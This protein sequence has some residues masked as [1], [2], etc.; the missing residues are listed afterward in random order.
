LY[1]INKNMKFSSTS[2][3][4]LASTFAFMVPTCRSADPV[5]S[6]SDEAI[7]TPPVPP[8]EPQLSQSM[9]EFRHPFFSAGFDDMFDP[10]LFRHGLMTFLANLQRGDDT[11]LMRSSPGYE[12]HED[13]EKYSIAIDVP[14]VKA[15]D[16]TITLEENGHVLNLSGGR[17]IKKGDSVTETKFVKTFTI[18]DN[19]DAD[20][21]AANLSDG[22]LEVTA[23]K[24]T[25]EEK[26]ETTRV[27]Q[28]TGLYCPR[29][30]H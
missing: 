26:R 5:L 27:I 9:R 14:G 8:A 23:P 30:E 29:E 10:R 22:V 2:A 20:K 15:H 16:M 19:V 11:I 1:E 13:D 28:I 17:K 24:K 25:E 18:G 4:I 7:E 21:I 12:I 6:M 3:I